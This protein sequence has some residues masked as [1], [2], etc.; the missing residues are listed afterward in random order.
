MEDF[1]NYENLTR[2]EFYEFLGRA[3]E[4]LYEDEDEDVPLVKKLGRFLTI[5]IEKFTSSQ[6]VF[7]DL[8]KEID[9]ESDDEDEMVQKVK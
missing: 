6:M 2:V 8:E 9:T 1:D 3:A 5:L 7:P 4:L